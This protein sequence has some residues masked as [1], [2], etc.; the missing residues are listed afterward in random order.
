V[1]GA[2]LAALRRERRELDRWIKVVE[3]AEAAVLKRATRS[4]CPWRPECAMAGR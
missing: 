2:E 3:Q 4:V 1:F